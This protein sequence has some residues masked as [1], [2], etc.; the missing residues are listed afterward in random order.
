[1]TEVTVVA[2]SRLLALLGQSL[3][4][5]QH[6]GLLPP[7][8][9]FDLFKG[10]AAAQV[11]LTSRPTFSRPLLFHALPISL[12]P[13]ST[14]PL[15]ASSRL[16]STLPLHR[17]LSAVSFPLHGFLSTPPFPLHSTVS[18]PPFPLHSTVS[19]PLHVSL[20]RFLST[21][22]YIK[23]LEDEQ[24]PTQVDRVIKFGTKS[25]AECARFSPDG[26]YLVTGSVDGF[27]EVWDYTSGKLNRNLP[28]QAR[29]EFMLHDTSVLCLAWSRDSE[30]LASGSQ[31]GKLKVWQIRTGKCMRKFEQAH[32]EGITCVAFARDGSQVLSGSFDRYYLLLF[33]CFFVFFFFVG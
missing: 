13:L 17:F 25:H 7:G 26:Q 2:P 18:S 32:A 24:P 10:T 20:H 3:K 16:F 9:K 14:L 11:G 22:S 30:Y 1:M 8:A 27:V 33:F 29:D 15:R 6:Q 12:L 21:N 31:D 28:Y 5:Q 19:S 23:V 4:W